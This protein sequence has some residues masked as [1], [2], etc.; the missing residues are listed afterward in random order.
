MELYLIRHGQSAS[1]ANP[2]NKSF[3][4]PLTELGERQA[5]RAGSEL[6]DRGIVR[7]YCSPMLRA[8]PAA[9]IAMLGPVRHYGKKEQEGSPS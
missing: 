9:T 8:L 1:N 7:L 6:A 3:E 4:P 5:R 2:A